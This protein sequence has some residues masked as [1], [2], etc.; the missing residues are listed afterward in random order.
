MAGVD[1]KPCGQ[2][3]AIGEEVG[4]GYNTEIEGYNYERRLVGG[5]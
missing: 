1:N 2:R 3:F 4:I 5:R